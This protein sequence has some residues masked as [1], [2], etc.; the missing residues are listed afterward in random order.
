M[1]PLEWLA[2][3]WFAKHEANKYLGGKMDIKSGWQ[4]SEFWG[5]HMTQIVSLIATLLTIANL[6]LTP[7]QQAAIAGLGMALV[8]IVQVFYTKGRTEVKVAQ[9]EASNPVPPATQVNTVNEVK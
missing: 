9:I 5:T 8:A 1:S 4:S 2:L 7:E 3:K 6:K